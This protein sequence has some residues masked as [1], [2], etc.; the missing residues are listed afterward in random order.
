MN[1]ATSVTGL[2]PVADRGGWLGFG[3][4][5]RNEAAQ[6]TR[7]RS[8][9]VQPLVW[10]AILVAPLTLPLVLMRD[11]FEAE[12]DGAFAMALQMP[13]QMGGLALP[14]GAI[15]LLHGA[16]LG[17]RERGTAAWILSKPASRSAFVLAKFVVHASALT[18]VGVLLPATAAYAALSLAGDRALPLA[19]F[20][21]AFGLLELNLLFYAALT[22]VLGAFAG[23]RGVVLAVGLI[24]LFG[25]DAALVVAPWL[26]E[27][28]PWML[29]RM[30]IVLADGG[31]L[32]SPWP[33]LVTPAW[34]VAFLALAVWRVRREEF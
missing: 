15:I 34:I 6:W 28:G 31:P 23:G 17:E 14:I 33:L 21:A 12:T 32:A 29:G 10:L 18:V 16:I 26:A 4:L 19:P 1:A 30:A 8:A 11:L 3:N 22:L 25:V 20:A 7:T 2:R 13:F 9:W 24:L 27:A 5:A